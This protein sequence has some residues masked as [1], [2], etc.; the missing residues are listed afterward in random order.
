MARMEKYQTKTK[1][2]VIMTKF[3][4]QIDEKSYKQKPQGKEIGGIKSRTQKSKPVYLTHE[5]FAD[6]IQ[7][8]IPFSLGILQGGL[9]ATNWKE[10]Q[11]F[12]VDIDNEDK[13]LPILTPNEAMKICKNKDL[14]PSICYKTFSSTEEK[15]KFRFIFT[16]DEP[17][18]DE[19]KRKLIAET[20]ISLF[21]Q[22]DKSCNNSDRIFFGTNNKV[23]VFNT[24]INFEKILEL[25]SPKIEV[26]TTDLDKLKAN[27]NFKELLDK[28]CGEIACST[29]TYTKY[30]TCPICGHK[31]DFVYYPETNTF[32]CFGANGNKGG[33]VIDYLMHTRKLSQKEAID[34]FKYEIC[35]LPREKKDECKK[36]S[37]LE[38]IPAK[39]LIK[40]KLAPINWCVENFL[41]Q[42]L[43]L[44]VA[45]PKTGKS[46]LTLQT[47]LNVSLGTDFLGYHTHKGE[48][49]YIA[50][51]DSRHRLKNRL[52]KI[53]SDREVPEN[54][55]FVIKAPSLANGLID[56]LEK[57]MQEHPATKLI[58]IDTLQKIRTGA[59]KQEGAYAAD[60]REVGMLKSFADE[61]NIAVL[62]VHHLRKQ[63]DSDVFNKIS[64]TNGIMGV[65]D[66]IYILDKDRR[67][68]DEAKLH[69]TGRDVESDE[70]YLRFNK[71]TCQWTC[72]GN[73]EVQEKKREIREYANDMVIKALRKLIEIDSNW[74]GTAQELLNAFI[75]K[76]NITV[77]EKPESIGRKLRKYTD[78]MRD[79]DGIIYTAPSVNGSNGR[80]EHKFHIGVPL[81]DDYDLDSFFK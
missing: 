33:S 46:W 69:I 68:S 77:D 63:K 23:K 43:A 50:L 19:G 28:E 17:V 39:Q 8:G 41:P 10:Q 44:T 81:A 14:I 53:L 75:D 79:V 27:C 40:Q 73:A 47:C 9:S 25:A 51:E 59:N 2:E 22:A 58:A 31:D 34:C 72:E 74:R 16:L 42:G 60:Y 30:K 55:N 20:L 66:T 70:L 54:F 21:P 13:S 56:V 67:E 52:E 26:G 3:L 29:S 57:H 32:R 48:T 5:E 36:P 4:I 6:K 65:A 61:H 62:L 76:C 7:R 18:K 35:G 49:L 71:S 24:T 37:H 11:L 12:G 78:L 1:K 80:R 45:Q 38:I 15:P 64:G